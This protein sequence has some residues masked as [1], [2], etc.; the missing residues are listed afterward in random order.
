MLSD[1]LP[2]G[3]HGKFTQLVD[4]SDHIL[5]IARGWRNGPL[6]REVDLLSGAAGSQ[7]AEKGSITYFADS[8][9]VLKQTFPADTSHIDHW[10]RRRSDQRCREAR[11]RRSRMVRRRFP[12]TCQKS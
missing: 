6:E 1:N 7:A 8:I 12:E 2:C 4:R 3:M 11:L 10:G 9:K 5:D